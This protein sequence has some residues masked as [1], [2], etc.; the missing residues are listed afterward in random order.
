MNLLFPLST[1]AAT[2][3]TSIIVEEALVADAFLATGFTLLATLAVLGLIEHWFL[4]L[5]LPVAGMWG[6]GLRF[7]PG[8]TPRAP[9]FGARR[10]RG[11]DTACHSRSSLVA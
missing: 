1:T 11:R 4:V 3:L 9:A 5:P 8:T 6:W 10:R 2:V 7:A